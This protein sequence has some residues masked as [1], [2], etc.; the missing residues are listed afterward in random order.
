MKQN[1]NLCACTLCYIRCKVCRVINV[2]DRFDDALAH[3]ERL[4]KFL[5]AI[6]NPARLT[7]Q[8]IP[9]INAMT[10]EEESENSEDETQNRE[11]IELAHHEEENYN[12]NTGD[13]EQINE[14]GDCKIEQ[15][16]EVVLDE[17]DLNAVDNLFD[18][19]EEGSEQFNDPLDQQSI[20]G[21]NEDDT[22]SSSIECTFESLNDFR[23]I[24]M[25]DGYFIKSHDILSN[26][27][28]FKTN[29]SF[30]FLNAH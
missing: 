22:S 13:Q 17:D 26:N 14:T 7:E 12:Q 19:D 23:P 24:V 1:Q 29:V 21:N 25:K 5:P 28:P 11:L 2:L 30:F 3:A 4:R 6:Y 9:S 18:G 20:N 15:F 8:P 10:R 27:I 16:D